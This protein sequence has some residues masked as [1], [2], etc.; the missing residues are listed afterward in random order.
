M[1]KIK[2]AFQYDRAG[3]TK[4]YLLLPCEALE[5]KRR[6]DLLGL[7]KVFFSYTGKPMKEITNIKFI[8]EED[9]VNNEQN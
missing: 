4:T 2:C 9:E 3:K 7:E 5:I 8:S 6:I 1:N